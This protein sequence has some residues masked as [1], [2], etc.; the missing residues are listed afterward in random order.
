[1]SYRKRTEDCQTKAN[2]KNSSGIIGKI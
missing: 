1:M 2:S